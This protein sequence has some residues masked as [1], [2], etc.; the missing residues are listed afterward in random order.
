[1]P[2][3]NLCVGSSGRERANCSVELRWARCGTDQLDA[4][5]C[6]SKLGPPAA[7]RSADAS[8]GQAAGLIGG[9]QSIV[10]CR[11]WRHVQRPL[12]T[13][14][15]P[16]TLGAVSRSPNRSDPRSSRPPLQGNHLGGLAGN[17]ALDLARPGLERLSLLIRVLV[18]GVDLADP[19][20]RT[21]DVIRYRL[22]DLD[23]EAEPLEAG[24]GGPPNVME[25]PMLRLCLLVMLLQLRQHCPVNPSLGARH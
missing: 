8:L 24:I 6:A 20:Q 11:R 14:H 13:E 21:A 25:R 17:D 10:R 9:E 23:R 22:R 3:C 18:L 7:W 5:S 4:L 15:I 12:A 1:M 2:G 16:R 19:A